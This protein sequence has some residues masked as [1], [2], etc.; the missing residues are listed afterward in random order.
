MFKKKGSGGQMLFDQCKKS[1]KFVFWASLN[2]SL[3]V[4][5]KLYKRQVSF[6]K[7]MSG[8][9]TNI[10]NFMNGVQNLDS[11]QSDKNCELEVHVEFGLKRRM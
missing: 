3:S 5:I 11:S 9:H 8:N 10:T 1:A 2:Q 7:H 6:V 4:R